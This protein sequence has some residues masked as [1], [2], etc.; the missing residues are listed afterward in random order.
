[1]LTPELVSLVLNGHETLPNSSRERMMPIKMTVAEE[2][3]AH[4]VTRW[5]F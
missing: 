5:N 4:P 2:L 3:G 1:L